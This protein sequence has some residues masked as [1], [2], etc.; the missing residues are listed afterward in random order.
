MAKKSEG[1]GLGRSFY[2]IMGDNVLEGKSG[3]GQS[4][5]LSD[6]EPRKDQPR[7]TF[8][9]EALEVLADSI[10]NY[11]V[12]QPI[13]VRENELM[14]GT[15]EIIAGERRWRAAKMA[16][17]SEI[18]AVVF[19]GDELKA[20]QVAMIENIQREDLNPVEE[21]MGYGALIERFGLTQ[22]QVA[23]QVGKN[24]ST[25]ANMLRLLDLPA[26]VLEMLRSGD[27]TTGHA[28]AL[29][30]LNTEEDIIET[31]NLVVS[32]SLSVREVEALVKRINSRAEETEDVEENVHPQIKAQMKELERRAM[33]SLGRKVRISRSSRKKVVELTYDNDKDLEA[34]LLMLCG[35]EIFNETV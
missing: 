21:A 5:R 31:A 30:A 10:A 34:L 35:Q 22:D 20:A 1:R 33:T 29:L 8:E 27:L 3:A 16:G 28:R 19:D 25:V 11:G 7:K 13:I 9:R 26:E 18:P 32:K 14:S 23:K 4:I 15:Y 17:L 24:R 6:I 12:L 2:D